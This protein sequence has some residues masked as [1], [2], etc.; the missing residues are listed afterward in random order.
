MGG[1]HA[2]G[3]LVSMRDA[4]GETLLRLSREHDKV[5]ALDGDLANS[6]KLDMVAEHNPAKF[7]QMGI[8]E[9]NMLGVAAGMATVGLQPWVCSFAPFIVKRA[10]D[11]ISVSIAQ[12]MLDVKLVG[13]YGGL[14]NGRTGKTHQAVEDV[15]VMR[16]LPGMT[17]L[18]PADSVE[19]AQMMDYACRTEGPVYLRVAR[20]AYPVL[21][22][23]T[24]RFEPGK[25]VIMREGADVTIVSTGTQTSRA[26][27]AVTLLER[28]GIRAG[29]IHM[30][31]I[32]PID[33]EAI[34]EAARRTG[35]IVT[36]EDHSVVGG[37]GSA[38]AEVLAETHPVPL[39]RVG[40]RDVNIESGPDQALLEKYG[41]TARYVVEKAWAVLARKK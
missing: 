39:E 33:R 35:A 3:T 41:L 25:A 31:S 11:Q 23:E 2:A 32:K 34:A 28:E 13:A 6:T 38:V 19:L 8:A 10:L 7:L 5:Y 15:A 30:P 26:L 36:A 40:V 27:E 20:D 21:F 1:G 14:L 17:V 4:F 18:A 24:Y 12:P 37:L 22:D 29:L 9:Q 16:S